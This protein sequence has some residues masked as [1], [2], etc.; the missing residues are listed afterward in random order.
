MLVTI[1]RATLLLSLAGLAALVLRRSSAAARHLVWASTLAG[2]LSLPLFVLLVPA[3]PVTVPTP[4]SAAIPY[5]PEANWSLILWAVWASGALAI[6]GRLALGLVRVQLLAT[7]ASDAHARRWAHL[8]ATCANRVGVR[9][10]V[11]LRIGEAGTVPVTC[12]TIRPLIILPLD[13][14]SWPD[15][16]LTLVLTHELAHVR[17]FD[18]ATHIVGQLALAAFW[19]H[20][21]VWLA[22]ARLRRERE[23]ACD[24]LVIATGAR[25]SRY[26]HDLLEL[27]DTLRATP[28]PAAAS[29]AMA[30]RTEIEGRLLAILDASIRRTPV[31]PRRGMASVGV[32]VATVLLLAALRPV[33]AAVTATAAAAII[34]LP[35]VQA[36]ARHLSPAATFANAATDASTLP[37]DAAKR[38][39]LLAIVPHYCGN[40]TLRRAFFAATY[41]IASPAERERVLTALR[42]HIHATTRH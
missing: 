35:P 25:P 11:G 7:R 3:L 9:R 17:R 23:R 8:L 29:L 42:H 20:P 14:A 1:L 39:A 37:S 34:S 10:P 2:L 15:E 24:D 16:R 28:A 31:G 5:R 36:I 30:R 38:A 21:L 19:F 40:D 18:V 6:L 12:G 27:A 22:T 13:A 32:A 4:P 33:A 41:S 26:A